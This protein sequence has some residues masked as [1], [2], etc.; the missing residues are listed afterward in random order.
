MISATILFVALV[1]FPVWMIPSIPDRVPSGLL[2]SINA[3]DTLIYL[4]AMN[5]GASGRW[6]A[7][8]LYSTERPAAQHPF[9]FYAALGA[10]AH[11]FHVSITTVYF[12]NR[13]LWAMVFILTLD[14]FLAFW[15]PDAAARAGVLLL[16]VF[17]GGFGSLVWP[18]GNTFISV[19]TQPHFAASLALML[20]SMGAF[21]R[22]VA[23]THG[24]RRYAL[25]S[26]L[27]LFLLGWIHPYDVI[28]VWAVLLLYACTSESPPLGGF[29]G[30]GRWSQFFCGP[31]L[32]SCALLAALFLAGALPLS[33]HFLFSYHTFTKGH[34]TLDNY[35]VPLW[36]LFFYLGPN[37]LFLLVLIFTSRPH[38][39]ACGHLPLPTGERETS[40]EAEHPSP[41][42]GEGPRVRAWRAHWQRYRFFWIWLGMAV[43][44]M[45]LPVYFRRKLFFGAPIAVSVLVGTWLWDLIATK[46]RAPLCE[47]GEEMPEGQRRGIGATFFFLLYVLL[48][49]TGT[50]TVLAHEWTSMRQGNLPYTLPR[51]LVTE[52]EQ[53]KTLAHG[54]IG[55]ITVLAKPEW[56]VWIP[57]LSGQRVFV[58]DWLWTA[59]KEK[60]QALTAQFFDPRTPEAWKK[61]FLKEQG[62]DDV[63]F[64]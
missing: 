1:V 35:G 23:A 7:E 61:Q 49:S 38:P 30:P 63:V 62:I 28:I 9:F 34:Y 15:I 36:H 5:Q 27:A 59:D 4:D 47:S 8:N 44:L 31:A 50:L 40:L 2:S 32:S 3:A 6:L 64:W 56:G 43:V 22:S 53:I 10:L 29:R 52:C 42:L 54:E 12:W 46:F 51:S 11:G 39:L 60:K 58:S 55:R 24:N 20:I 26:I 21:V 41:L 17:S 57:V 14:W 19:Y 48:A 16:S 37:A 13:I 25:I 33:W 45:H 18:E